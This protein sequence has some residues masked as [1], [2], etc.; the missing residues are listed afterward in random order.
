[1]KVLEASSGGGE[2]GELE[3]RGF[4]E[5]LSECN[6]KE[7][8]KRLTTWACVVLGGFWCWVFGALAGRGVPGYSPDMIEVHGTC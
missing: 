5:V 8:Q 2:I 4:F 1:M 6:A 7:G 3:K